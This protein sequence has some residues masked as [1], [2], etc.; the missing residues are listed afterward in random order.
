VT[1][2]PALEIAW[3]QAP[4][5]ESCI[6][7]RE[8]VAK[9]ESVVGRGAF[10]PAGEGA[11]IVLGSVGPAAAGHGWVAVV[12][13]RVGGAAATRREVRVDTPDCR[14][15]DEAIVLVV[16]LMADSTSEGPSRPLVLRLPAPSAPA[17]IG[18]GLD[19]AATFGMLPGVAV[20][21]GLA[22]EITIPPVWP[23][24]L[25]THVWLPSQALDA[26]SGG[27]L[28]AYTFG[29]GLCPLSIEEPRWSVAG[30][31]GG[32]AGVIDSSGV[33]LDVAETQ[34][35][36]FAEGEARAQ[37]RVRVAGPV[38]VGLDIAA[39]LPVT[40]HAYRF[41]Q[42]DGTVHDVFQTAA[43]VPEAGARLEM[44]VP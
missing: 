23:I 24:L 14:E 16:A 21:L 12:E 35:R 39:G 43:V 44:R 9:V 5:G 3:S 34:T 28:G 33:A 17:S 18:I 6:D 15:L 36:A 7:R 19:V 27:R 8:L 13:A 41:T 2:A 32:S 22:S 37:V 31:L 11:T 10:A 20:G 42:A 1:V 25:W 26:G 40:R 38:F 4:G 30:C 29:A